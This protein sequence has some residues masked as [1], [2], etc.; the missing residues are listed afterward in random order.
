MADS[1]ERHLLFGLIALQ[2]GLID[3]AQLVAAFQAWARYKHRPLV[4]H[5][6]AS[7]HL[8]REHCPL[9]DGLV[10]VHLARHG[11]DA[12][13]SLAA[14]PA[15]RSTRESLARIGDA[16]LGGTLS[17][18]GV[19]A[20]QPDADGESDRTAAYSVGT[21]TSDGQ[22]FRM[23]RPHAQGGLGAVFVALDTELH[24][25]VALKQ[26]LDHF[27]DDQ[28]SRQR[29]LLEAEVTGGLEHPGIVPVYGLGTYA[30][31]RPYYAMRLIKGDSLKEAIAAFHADVALKKHPGRRSLELRKLL[32]RFLDVCNAIDYAHSRGILHRDIKPG[33]IIVGKHGETLVVDWGLAKPLG[34]VEPGAHAGERTLRPSSASGSAETLPGSALGTPAYMSPEQAGG[35]LERLGPRS[36]VYSLG[37]TLYCVLIGRPPVERDDIGELLR[38]VQRGEFAR[39][40]QVEPSIDRALEAVC[41]KAMATKPEDRYPSC[42]ALAE[43]V[44]RW[45]ADEPVSAYRDPLATRL[46]RWGR[47]HRTFAASLAVLMASAVVGLS[48]GAFLINGERAKAEANFRQARAA[49]DEYFTNVSESRLLK[50][51]GLQ[52][53]RKE[54][55]DSALKYYR[56]FLSQRGHD[57]KVRVETASASFRVGW[58]NLTLN[59][60]DE[61]LGPLTAATELY[62]SLA[63][64]SPGVI[65][66]RR[67]A[68]IG[69]GALGLL[70]AGQ[71]RIDEA[72]REHRA[73]LTIREA[74]VKVEPQNALFL[75]D[76]ARS[77]RNI[78]DLYNQAGKMQQ[79]LA[80]WDHAVT[81]GRALVAGP[82]PAGSHRTDLTGRSDPSAILREDLG[83]VQ[84]NRASV[85]RETG[86][87]SQAQDA[88]REAR[89]LFE[90]LVQESPDDQAFLARLAQCQSDSGLLL[91]DLGRIE[92]AQES[93]RR[94]IAL[95]EKLAATN[96]TLSSYP[97]AM[98]G[99]RLTLAW[100]L[101]RQGRKADALAM[102]HQATSTAESLA[103]PG[104]FAQC[105]CQTA[106]LL[107]EMGRSS[108][109]SPMA[110]R[111]RDIQEGLAR[112]H[113]QSVSDN[114]SLATALRGVGRALAASGRPEEARQALERAAEIDRSFAET[115]PSIRYNLACSLALLIPVS[116][117][118]RREAIA[119]QAIE[120]LCLSR[121]AGYA[122]AL[123][124]PADPDLNALR[125][126]ADFRSF[127]SDVVFP[128]DPFAR[129]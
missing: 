9:L 62:E 119:T 82:L 116:P 65:E 66:Y 28:V 104:L 107:V 60:P 81:L 129:R 10:A 103:L 3:Q 77:H 35:D 68:A 41:L 25:E 61:A 80:E 69:H 33:N 78:G 7:G 121:N 67:L 22:R 1:P 99:N 40:R 84:L 14:I 18:V 30:D 74:L 75:G 88:W 56:E 120:A 59:R 79:A 44:E 21:A 95:Q 90:G 73:A 2:V 52:P 26:I 5:L 96:P 102:L 118:D 31:G 91:L 115:Y 110:Q 87:Y 114:C 100:I 89:E 54:L 24:R 57:P 124:L 17:R 27:A 128:S 117:P 92:E 106:N 42:R 36:D 122:N 86:R 23:L 20:T 11:G 83:S 34:R 97:A 53:L 58:I 50:V 101:N 12:E 123:I 51:P 46:T 94:A 98:T 13:R 15:G 70:L 48:V 112:D 32:R 29:F 85:L 49:V 39:P 64:S 127:L 113:P 6:L 8:E 72:M 38:Q 108:E 76:V 45:M 37:A 105:L 63:R 16:G 126:R 55:L 43:D 71:S 4:E 93:I 109:A 47:R 19:H 125:D 111:A